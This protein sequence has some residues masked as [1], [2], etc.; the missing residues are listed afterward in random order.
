[1]SPRTGWQSIEWDTIVILAA[2]VGISTAVTA[3]GLS[4]VIAQG[5]TAIGGTSP[6]ISLVMIFL[7]C[8]LLTNIITNAAAASIMFPVALSLSTS[9]G[10]S[11]TPYAVVLMLGTSY[12]FIN[13]AGYQTNLMVQDPGNYTFSDFARVG[14]PL[15]ILVGAIVLILTPLI[16]QF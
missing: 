5:I 16:Y 15:T 9:L 4:D 14:L 8:I 11:F 2:A 7:G 3:T 6:Y 10:V 13:P 1:M 12:A